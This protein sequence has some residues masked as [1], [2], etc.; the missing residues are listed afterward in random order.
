MKFSLFNTGY[1]YIITWLAFRLLDI[2]ID[3]WILGVL[4]CAQGVVVTAIA[5]YTELQNTAHLCISL[6]AA[7]TTMIIYSKLLQN[8]VRAELMQSLQ[9]EQ[10]E[11]QES[12]IEA[13]REQRHEILND[14]AVISSYMQL[15]MFS[16]ARQALD[17]LTA[18]LAD[19]Y[20]YSE[21]PKDAWLSMIQQKQQQ[22]NLMD[23]EL[24]IRLET[25][26]PSDFNEQRLLPKVA[27][28][29][30][31]NAFEAVSTEPN[32]RVEFIWRYV[33][34]YRILS[35]ENNGPAIPTDELD[36]L[37]EYGYSSKPGPNRGWGLPLCKRIAIEL[38]GSLSVRTSVHSTKFIFLL[39]D[40]GQ[41]AFAEVAVTREDS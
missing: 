19:R 9:K 33:G 16:K 27:T 17:F 4:F 2:A 18:K 21:L 1:I 15:G 28:L 34:H 38:G 20:N 39:V 13:M 22:A 5:T 25:D 12:A 23:I 24:V 35:V 3:P 14:L 32:P 37:F 11:I 30:L 40:R 10:L 31:D 41:E 36:K 29:L 26:S 8:N 6:G 7:Y